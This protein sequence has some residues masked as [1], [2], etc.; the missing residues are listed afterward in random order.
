MDQTFNQY[1]VEYRK[2]NEVFGK[3][4]RDTTPHKIDISSPFQLVVY[5]DTKKI[6]ID[7][8]PL[9]IQFSADSVICWPFT[10]S[11]AMNLKSYSPK[12]KAMYTKIVEKCSEIKE[13]SN[14]YLYIPS[15]A[16]RNPTSEILTSS[17]KI[18]EM[19]SYLAHT[20]NATAYMAFEYTDTVLYLAITSSLDDL[21]QQHKADNIAF[22]H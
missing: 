1:A 2:K 6:K 15:E 22:I 5:Y 17:Y 11:K 13:F 21:I 9:G 14:E 12:H 18:D 19:L 8:I 3:R 16:I 20:I 10:R 7:T 4:I